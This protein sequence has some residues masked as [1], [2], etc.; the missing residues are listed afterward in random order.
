MDLQRC[1]LWA[2]GYRAWIKKHSRSI[3]FITESFY[4]F[5]F[6]FSF[7]LYFDFRLILIVPC[8]TTGMSDGFCKWATLAFLRTIYIYKITAYHMI[9]SITAAASGNACKSVYNPYA[10]KG[11]VKKNPWSKTPCASVQSVGFF[12]PSSCSR[13]L[14]GRIMARLIYIHILIIYM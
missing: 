2:C 8:R 10:S 14:T 1:A 4:G 3:G 12:W 9:I 11:K 13:R 6:W 5:V 7:D